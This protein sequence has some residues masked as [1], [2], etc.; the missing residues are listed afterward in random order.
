MP[1]K[2]ISILRLSAF[3]LPITNGR[4]TFL[5]LRFLVLVV[6]GGGGRR[7]LDQHRRYRRRQSF[8]FEGSPRHSAGNVIL[9][10]MKTIPSEPCSSPKTSS[11]F[12]GTTNLTDDLHT[13]LDDIDHAIL[14]PFVL[15]E[16]NLQPAGGHTLSQSPMHQTIRGI[17]E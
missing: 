13:L 5:D 16:W 10:T 2:S 6:N 4:S 14:D 8:G 7:W 3:L 17:P 9:E 1:Q 15:L 11:T 12:E